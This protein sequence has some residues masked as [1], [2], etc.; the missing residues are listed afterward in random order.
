MPEMS[1]IDSGNIEN[2]EVIK[3]KPEY[4]DGAI[5]IKLKK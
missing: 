2:I 1:K 4:P 3:N 5:Y